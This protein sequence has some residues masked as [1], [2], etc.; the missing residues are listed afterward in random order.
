MKYKTFKIPLKLFIRE[1]NSA[2]WRL[3][4][5]QILS[6]LL[7]TSKLHDCTLACGF[8]PLYKWSNNIWLQFQ[9]IW[10][11][12]FAYE[13]HFSLL[14]LWVPAGPPLCPR[15]IH[16]HAS[17]QQKKPWMF[18][19]WMNVWMWLVARSALSSHVQSILPF[20]QPTYSHVSYHVLWLCH[21]P[22]GKQKSSRRPTVTQF[23]Y[24][25]YAH[26]KPAK[27][28]FALVF[29]SIQKE[30]TEIAC[31]PLSESKRATWRR[32]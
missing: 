2:F 20:T 19:I 17:M 1:L 3:Y 16:Q 30:A 13:R 32:T 15:S 23:P 14:K 18:R 10:V 21:V 7:S 29:K 31:Q 12:I 28:S 11:E 9:L 27:A 22:P 24:Q 25:T 26:L 6:D 8:N 5:L 4:D